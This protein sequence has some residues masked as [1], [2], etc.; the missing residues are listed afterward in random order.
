MT[1]VS[2]GRRARGAGGSIKP[3]A[4]APGSQIKKSCRAREAGDSAYLIGLSPAS[5]ARWLFVSNSILGL[6]PQ[7]LCFRPLRGL[8]VRLKVHVLTNHA[9]TFYL[10]NHALTTGV[11][12]DSDSNH[13]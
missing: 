10:A 1:S 4:Q 6:A 11:V 2:S 9:R 7:A 3:G 8:G 5:R 13:G 12:F